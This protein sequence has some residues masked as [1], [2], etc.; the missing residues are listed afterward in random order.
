MSL[1]SFHVFFIAVS[2]LLSAGMGIRSLRIFLEEQALIQLAWSLLA[3]GAA[4]ALLIY[5][6]RFLKKLKDV[7]YL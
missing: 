2:V 1:K 4:L 7:S 5:G 3:F 6:R